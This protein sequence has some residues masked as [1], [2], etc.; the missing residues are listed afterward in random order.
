MS[1]NKFKFI[2]LGY[3]IVNVGLNEQDYVM[4]KVKMT[5]VGNVLSTS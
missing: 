2:E 5:W 1:Q 3:V 4:L